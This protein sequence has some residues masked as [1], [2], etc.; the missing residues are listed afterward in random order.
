M[1]ENNLFKT[2]SDLTQ[3][4]TDDVKVPELYIPQ[5]SEDI[6]NFPKNVKV[7]KLVD[8]HIILAFAIR[9]MG[10]Q[11]N[12]PI[13]QEFIKIAATAVPH[14]YNWSN[15]DMLPTIEKTMGEFLEQ[16][17][18]YEVASQMALKV[19]GHKELIKKGKYIDKWELTEPVWAPV[20][21]EDITEDPTGKRPDIVN[22]RTIVLGGEPAGTII[23]QKVT[24]KYA[25]YML[26]EIGTPKFKRVH[27][28]ELFHTHFMVLLE[29]GKT[30]E[31]R[32]SKFGVNSFQSKYNKTL[33]KN[34]HAC[35]NSK[36]FCVRCE[37]T[38]EQ[39]DFAVR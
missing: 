38:F 3:P 35:T 1:K 14:I 19:C 39:C 37:K 24:K 23:T 8:D 10:E 13:N 7:Q 32:M 11:D 15:D 20:Y 16:K 18:T 31:T 36:T 34:R 12:M 30:G 21:V 6:E 9:K 5:G 25:S 17:V 2:W 28:L 33:Y 29:K 26:K 27:P 4:E 22:L